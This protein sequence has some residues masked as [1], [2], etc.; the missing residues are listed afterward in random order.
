M[1]NNFNEYKYDIETKELQPTPTL[2]QYTETNI[3][4]ELPIINQFD[5]ITDS[6]NLIDY[7]DYIPEL[8]SLESLHLNEFN[9]NS[10][11]SS[12]QIIDKINNFEN[13]DLFEFSPD[14]KENTKKNNLK[15]ENKEI[16]IN[17]NTNDNFGDTKDLENIQTSSTFDTGK[18]LENKDNVLKDK[19]NN[20]N[21]NNE[22]IDNILKYIDNNILKEDFGNNDYQTDNYLNFEEL[23]STTEL[24]KGKNKNKNIDLY[25]PNEETNNNNNLLQTDNQNIDLFTSNE[26]F[27]DKY[28]ISTLIDNQNN[29]SNFPNEAFKDNDL[30]LKD[31]Q[32]IDTYTKIETNNNDNNYLSSIDNQIIDTYVTDGNI[33]S[34]KLVND[35][36]N[37][38]YK[39]STD[40]KNNQNIDSYISNNIINNNYSTDNENIDLN[41]QNEIINDNNLLSTNSQN[42]TNDIN[43]NKVEYTS[44]PS[45]KEGPK[46]IGSKITNLKLPPIH[47]EDEIEHNKIKNIIIPYKKEIIVPVK[48]KIE[49]PIK[50]KI[51]IPISKK[52]EVQV[53]KV[54]ALSPSKNEEILPITTTYVEPSPSLIRYDSPPINTEQITIPEYNITS[55]NMEA[56]LIDNTPSV[57]ASSPTNYS[58]EK[59]KISTQETF[60]NYSN[61]F[62]YKIDSIPQK[63][64]VNYNVSSP[65]IEPNIKYNVLTNIIP[66]KNNISTYPLQPSVI[67]SPKSSPNKYNISTT[68]IKTMPIKYKYDVFTQSNKP[69][70][71]YSASSN[72]IEIPR[73]INSMNAPLQTS[74]F[75]SPSQKNYNY[76]SF[77]SNESHSYNN[78]FNQHTSPSKLYHVPRQKKQKLSYIIR[79]DSLNFSN[80]NNINTYS[81]ETNNKYNLHSYKST[82]H[83]IN[84]N[85]SSSIRYN[86]PIGYDNYNIN[87]NSDYPLFNSL[88]YKTFYPNDK[89][90]SPG[91][92]TKRV[93]SPLNNDNLGNSMYRPKR[94][95]NK[96]KRKKKIIYIKKSLFEH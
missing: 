84:N 83:I 4:N 40:N 60:D 17:N 34:N 37:G 69:K 12:E 11:E 74:I 87:S 30:L 36:L 66:V 35:I 15:N 54:T 48:T 28:L 27:N 5:N 75:Y 90:L 89:S 88:N 20:P 95:R 93:F 59:I 1:S 43:E 42:I 71:K 24:E 96:P 47:L 26:A 38:K 63:S 57:Q 56:P 77:K 53:P 41:N 78:L 10:Y 9:K 86:S 14:N 31:N 19:D 55:V 68:K 94:F 44:Y 46:Y 64:I 67:Y 65:I 52:I 62:N 18:I 29:D 45:I 2:G 81:K 70:L 79:T 39:P 50:K 51:Q 16:N 6:E 91:F 32:N 61:H 7:N 33:D 8:K 25:T 80:K 21:N 3:N 49:V 73:I 76:S 13:N 85:N 92:E 58:P 23:P 72:L 82:P 22:E